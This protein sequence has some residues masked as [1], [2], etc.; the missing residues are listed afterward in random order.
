MQKESTDYI[1]IEVQRNYNSFRLQNDDED[2]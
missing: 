2:R 1:D